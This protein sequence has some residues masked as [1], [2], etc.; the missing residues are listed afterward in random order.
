MEPLYAELA[1]SLVQLGFEDKS[2]AERFIYFNKEYRLVIDLFPKKY[3]ERLDA[4]R[5]GMVSAQLFHFGIIEH[6]DDLGKMIKAKRLA[7]AA[8]LP[9]V[10]ASTAAP[11]AK[12][13]PVEKRSAAAQ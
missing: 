5:F 11:K 13:S 9:P 1:E 4:G 8:M 6:R 10:P 3:H 2:T 12:K 7:T